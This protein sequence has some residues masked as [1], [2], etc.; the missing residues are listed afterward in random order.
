[1]MREMAESLELLAATRSLLVVCEDL[2]NSDRSTVDLIACLA[3]RREPARLM[4]VA[5]YRSTE[6]S[7]AVRRVRA[8]ERELLPRQ[9]SLESSLLNEAAVAQY[10]RYRTGKDKVPLALTSE[11]S[12]TLVAIRCLSPH[13]AALI[14]PFQH[15]FRVES[16]PA[17]RVLRVGRDRRRRTGRGDPGRV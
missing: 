9:N 14:N 8:I 13:R 2:H 1:M 6:R 17:G 7:R 11:V 5:T 12:G 10:L 3:R 16:A 4:M 15:R